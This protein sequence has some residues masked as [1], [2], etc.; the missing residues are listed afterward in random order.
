MAYEIFALSQCK[1]LGE[2]IA[3]KCG[4]ELSIL[5][6]EVFSDG[7]ISVSFPNSLRGKHVYLI[8]S[9]NPNADNLME[10]LLALDASK[11]AGAYKVHVVSPYFGFARQDKKGKTRSALGARVVARCLE[12]NGAD[13][14]MCVDLHAS[15]IQGFFSNSTPVIEIEGKDIFAPMLIDEVN[16]EEWLICSPDAGG[17]KRAKAMKDQ[18]ELGMVLMDKTRDKPNSIGEMTLI[19]DVKGKKVIIVDD[20]VDTAGTLCASA[21]VLLERGATE[22]YACIA[23]GILS[24]VAYERIGKSKLKALYISDT[25]PV[26]EINDSGVTKPSNIKV[27]SCSDTIAKIIQATRENHSINE[28][29]K[30]IYYPQHS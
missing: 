9:T 13:S 19:G 27:V 10:M 3:Q 26:K 14:V 17:G 28:T 24:G 22:V 21:E 6:T 5:E 11:T 18:L 12:E 20:M 23:H 29:I 2:K 7:E 1:E 15:Q 30:E 8:G 25:I 16:S 4:K